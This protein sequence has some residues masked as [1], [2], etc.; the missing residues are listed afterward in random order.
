MILR[1]QKLGEMVTDKPGRP[2]NHN[3][4]HLRS[5]HKSWKYSGLYRPGQPNASADALRRATD[6]DAAIADLRQKEIA[7]VDSVEVFSGSL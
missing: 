6:V 1:Q 2:G 3:T 7:A 4:R 5:A